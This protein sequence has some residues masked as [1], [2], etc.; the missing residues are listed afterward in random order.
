M[1]IVL[2]IDLYLAFFVA[3]VLDDYFTPCLSAGIKGERPGHRTVNVQVNLSE[4]ITAEHEQQKNSKNTRQ[5][6]FV[7]NRPVLHLVLTTVKIRLVRIFDPGV[8]GEIPA[9]LS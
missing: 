1:K 2:E 4:N 7:Q 9:I 8:R 3:L 5:N 6:T